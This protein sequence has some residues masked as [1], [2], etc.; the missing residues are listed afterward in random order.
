MKKNVEDALKTILSNEQVAALKEEIASGIKKMNAAVEGNEKMKA[1]KELLLSSLSKVDKLI[2]TSD[3]SP[4]LFK[5]FYSAAKSNIK[6]F[7]QPIIEKM[8]EEE[9]LAGLDDIPDVQE[10]QEE[11]EVKQEPGKKMEEKPAQ[12]NVHKPFKKNRT[13]HHNKPAQ[14]QNKPKGP[15]KPKGK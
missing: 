2:E 5:A 12:K 3:R 7:V 11:Q 13:Q 9:E 14:A 1:K 10:K 15:V 8:I 6:K 4:V